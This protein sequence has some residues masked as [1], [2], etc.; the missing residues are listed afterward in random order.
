VH[1]NKAMQVNLSVRRSAQRTNWI[2]LLAIVACLGRR[3]HLTGAQLV[4]KTSSKGCLRLPCLVAG[5]L[6]FR[7]QV[8]KADE[9]IVSL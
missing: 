4:E 6:F 9:G 8:I 3:L 7:V 1:Q 2:W 5:R